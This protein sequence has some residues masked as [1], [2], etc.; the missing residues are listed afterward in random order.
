MESSEDE[1]TS[2][3]EDVYEEMFGSERPSFMQIGNRIYVP[4]VDAAKR[5]LER[6]RAGG[7]S[8]LYARRLARF[9]GGNPQDQ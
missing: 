3:V 7:V 9:N 2:S 8:S 6:R 1:S 4:K 5:E